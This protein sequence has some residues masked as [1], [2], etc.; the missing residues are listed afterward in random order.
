[1]NLVEKIKV[2]LLSIF[3]V[4]FIGTFSYILI[5]AA[6][7]PNQYVEK[8]N[9]WIVIIMAIV[10]F[11][12]LF[13]CYKVLK[14]FSKKSL[15]VISGI[16]FLIFIALQIFFFK[17]FQVKPSWDVGAIYN[18]ALKHQEYIGNLSSYF[19]IRYPNNIPM[20]LAEIYGMRILS[21]FGIENFYQV[22]TAFN[23]II[24]LCSMFGLYYLSY[25]RVGLLGATWGSLLML[26]V[27][28]LYTY[29]PIFYTDT[30]V[31]P[32]VIFGVLLYDIFYHSKGKIRYLWLVILSVLLA[33]GVLFKANAIIFVV[34]MFIHYVMT[35]NY[36]QWLSFL[37]VF[38]IPFVL[39][40]FSYQQL[41]TPLYPMEKSE[42][43]FPTTHWI[44]M[45][46]FDK[47]GYYNKDVQFTESL[48]V[49]QGLSNKEITKIH[50]GIIKERLTENGFQ[51]FIKHINK[52][53]N[54]TW[55]EG[56][57]FAPVKLSRQ[58]LEENPYATYIYGESRSAF[59]YFCQA[60]QLNI[61]GLL[62]FAGF[63]LFTKKTTFE[64]VLSITLFGTFL[65]LLI[66]E[67]RS[68][69]LVLML[70]VMIAM[71]TYGMCDKSNE[72]KD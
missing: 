20:L 32:F 34:A 46:T 16:N 9:A 59:V 19:T 40:N 10:L 2:T 57:Y 15:M 28:P 64:I 8:M 65:F 31:M 56:T 17:Y 25:R 62:V 42:V 23:A 33:V 30:L 53:L 63:K 60:V 41:V 54:Y 47:G 43:G 7:F 6:L 22:F 55:A 29:T 48:K 49:E 51:G 26:I 37:G 11:F 68:R 52:K 71:C 39:I 5:N 50:L 69:Y 66:W 21:L 12:I 35:R 18:E 70:P 44:M 24:V 13:G 61:L 36:Q 67:T 4:L 1:M 3:N 45:G 38:I 14:K 27:T 58:P 72:W